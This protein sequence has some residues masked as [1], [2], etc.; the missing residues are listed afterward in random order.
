MKK[1]DIKYFLAANSCE[2][3]YSVFDKAYL[4]D[5]EWRAYIIKG[6]PGTGKSSFMKR[7]A[8]YAEKKGCKALRCPC[9]SDP[10][11][12]D[13]VILPDKKMIILDGTAPH[14]VDPSYPGVCEKILNF[15]EFWRDGD[16]S[17]NSREIIELTL[18]NKALHASAARY[19]RAAGQLISD[20]YK[21]ALAC[22]DISKTEQLAARLCKRLIPIKKNSVGREWVRFIGGITPKGINTFTKTA[23][24]EA[25][26]LIIISDR[27][28][29]ASN[30]II[31]AARG[32]ALAAGYEIITLKNPFLPSL[33]TDHVIIPELKLAFVTEND[34][35]KFAS[36]ER[37]VH[38]RRFVALKKLHLSNER[39]KFNRK[40]A[41]LLLESAA[42]TLQKAKSVHDELEAFYIG[43]MDFKALDSYYE[44]FLKNI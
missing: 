24:C 20:N 10:D 23:E 4:P 1:N 27:Y 42:A 37:R 43:A 21:T 17:A 25:E 6:G 40:A 34:Y 31:N 11:S 9:S 13:A 14:T 3:F 18:K 8:S 15:G 35:A 19:L 16:F 32:Y 7:F 38:S 22:T 39:M 29:S 41:A 2:G 36:T 28:G 5:G 33:I 12:L 44:G 30:I 26:R